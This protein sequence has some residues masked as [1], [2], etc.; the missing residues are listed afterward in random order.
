MEIPVHRLVIM[1]TVR[2]IAQ[3]IIWHFAMSSDFMV[4]KDISKR[5]CLVDLKSNLSVSIVARHARV[6]TRYVELWV[7]GV[8]LGILAE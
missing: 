7:E 2:Y 3:P 8:K 1:Q 5:L 6:V 4:N